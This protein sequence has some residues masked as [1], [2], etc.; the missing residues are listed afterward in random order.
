MASLVRTSCRL[1]E[2]TSN[3]ACQRKK[4]IFKRTLQRWTNVLYGSH[5]TLCVTGLIIDSVHCL[6]EKSTDFINWAQP[7][8]LPK[9]C[10]VKD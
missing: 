3:E 1:T 6:T 7:A 8:Q 9:T 2:R 10:A 4:S 5:N